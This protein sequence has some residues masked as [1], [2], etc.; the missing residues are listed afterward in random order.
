MVCPALFFPAVK[1]S[2]QWTDKAL[3]AKLLKKL[4]GRI[5]VCFAAEGTDH[6][7]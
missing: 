1:S 6:E 5:P 4:C 3:C 7:F 2:V